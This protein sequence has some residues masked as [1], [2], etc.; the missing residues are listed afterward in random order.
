MPK[1]LLH[2]SEGFACQP[3]TEKSSLHVWI[4]SAGC[5]TKCWH[6]V[7]WNENGLVTDYVVC[8]VVRCCSIWISQSQSLVGVI[9]FRYCPLKPSTSVSH[10]A[11]P[12][13]SGRPHYIPV[14]S[15]LLSI[16]LSY[17]LPTVHSICATTALK[18]QL[19]LGT[20]RGGPITA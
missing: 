17:S 1:G 9:S 19:A 10:P 11:C 4:R 6:V 15:D 3:T 5:M 20:Q 7:S 8:E 13:S 12:S 14:C 18:L 16:C 2:I